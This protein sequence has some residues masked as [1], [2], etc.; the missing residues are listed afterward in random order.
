MPSGPAT[1]L[2]GLPVI[3]EVW[4][5]GPDYQGEYDAGV[6]GLY[7]QR[8]DGSAGSPLSEKIMKRLP[9]YWQGDVLE[10]VSDY[11]AMRDYVERDKVQLA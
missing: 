7:W 8:S 6:D 2:G 4:F 3:A 11:L 9:D 1:I 10:Q 5:S